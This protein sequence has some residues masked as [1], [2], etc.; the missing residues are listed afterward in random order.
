MSQV[1]LYAPKI[2][3]SIRF[4]NAF[5]SHKKC[6]TPCTGSSRRLSSPPLL[7]PLIPG[8][9]HGGCSCSP[10]VSSVSSRRVRSQ[11]HTVSHF[12][13]RI[14]SQRA[15]IPVYSLGES[16][17]CLKSGG[18]RAQRGWNKGT[19]ACVVG[20]SY[21][22]PRAVLIDLEPGTMDSVHSGLLGGLFRPDNFVFSQNGGGNDW[23]KGR[24]FCRLALLA[25]QG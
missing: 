23:T 20:A 2:E 16:P 12:R 14:P 15:R 22:A 9:I 10:S 19:G 24:T 6:K 25:D 21:Y 13:S 1:L 8:A 11:Q 3:S 7:C 4:G 18:N 5:H 17:T